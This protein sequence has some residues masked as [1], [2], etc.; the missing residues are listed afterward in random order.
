LVV[1]CFFFSSRRRHTRSKRDWSSDVCSS[2]LDGNKAHNSAGAGI[3]VDAVAANEMLENATVRDLHVVRTKGAGIRIRSSPSGPVNRRSLVQSCV[4][5]DTDS[6][7]IA[8]MATDQSIVANCFVSRT[9]NHG[10]I[11]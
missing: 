2:D 8:L 1:L 9:G 7:G 11:S 5:D 4:V 6:E 10:I 3:L